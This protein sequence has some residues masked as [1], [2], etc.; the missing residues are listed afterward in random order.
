M[1]VRAAVPRSLSVRS[2]NLCRVG[3]RAVEL[4]P[5]FHAFFYC[6]F[7]NGLAK[8]SNLIQY[9]DYRDYYIYRTTQVHAIF[10]SVFA[11]AGRLSELVC[12]VNCQP[13]SGSSQVTPYLNFA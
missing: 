13:G 7:I 8:P 2:Q 9:H 4:L 3:Q 10:R 1:D 5:P 6:Q 12:L 11:D